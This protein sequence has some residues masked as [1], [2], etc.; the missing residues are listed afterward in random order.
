MVTKLP[1]P[2][3]EVITL[4]QGHGY[5]PGKLSTDNIVSGAYRYIDRIIAGLVNRHVAYEAAAGPKR[6]SVKAGAANVRPGFAITCYGGIDKS[7]VFVLYL[8]IAQP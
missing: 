4:E 2:Y 3:M 8:L 6:Y 1:V 5:G 7:G